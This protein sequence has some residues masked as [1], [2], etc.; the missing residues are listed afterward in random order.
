MTKKRV[1]AI[2]CD[3][4]LMHTVGPILDYYNRQYDTN[5]IPEVYYGAVPT[6]GVWGTDNAQE[7]NVRINAFFDAPEY[8]E[9]TP[10]D[11]V[12]AVLQRLR[13]ECELHIIT[14]RPDFVKS[15][16]LAWLDRHLP[17]IFE[18]VTFTEIFGPKARSK[19][20]VCREIG[21]SFLVDDH[22]G[23]CRVVADAGMQALLFGNYPWNRTVGS[24]PNVR[25][26]A[27]WQEVER[28]I[29]AA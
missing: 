3:D 21:A 27:N 6:A 26:V 18:T 5:V 20:D 2:D 29:N 8:L 9:L 19:A 13:K 7:R 16:T 22:P 14:G 12:L 4:V 23:H 24:Y 1:V 15:Q 11:G 17:G 25:R 10:Q 28:A